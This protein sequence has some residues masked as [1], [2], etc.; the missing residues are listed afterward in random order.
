M[1]FPG[2]LATRNGASTAGT[3][4]PAPCLDT[5]EVLQQ[6]Q[7]APH[8]FLPV[9][10]SGTHKMAGPLQMPVCLCVSLLSYRCA[11]DPVL[12]KKNLGCTQAGGCSVELPFQ[13]LKTDR[14]STQLNGQGTSG[15]GLFTFINTKRMP[16]QQRG[17]QVS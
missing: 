10:F 5:H 11:V 1:R 15:I 3:T 4:N 14:S 9:S 17:L 13:P 16:K 12:W 7:I 2:E 6:L 8:F